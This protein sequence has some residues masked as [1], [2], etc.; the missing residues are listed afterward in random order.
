M[1]DYFYFQAFPVRCKIWKG[2]PSA[3]NAAPQG[4]FEQVG[5][6]LEICLS[7]ESNVG[8]F[9]FPGVSSDWSGW[10]DWS[11]CNSENLQKRSRFCLT[12]KR[13]QCFG[14]GTETRT[15]IFV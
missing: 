7:E 5:V 1:L 8:L 6:S 10:S 9:L 3:R 2:R 15:C 13:I 4:G 12:Q 14:A 11:A